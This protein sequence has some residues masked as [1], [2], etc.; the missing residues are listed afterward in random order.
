M[1]EAA[2]D[3]HTELSEAFDA[4][5]ASDGEPGT[6]VDTGGGGDAPAVSE[7]GGAESKPAKE[8]A[9]ATDKSA[10]GERVRDEHGRFVKQDGKPETEKQEKTEQEAEKPQAE[11]TGELKAAEPKEQQ[12]PPDAPPSTWRPTAKAEWVK[13]PSHVREEIKKR[14]ADFQKGVEQYKGAAQFGH[15]VYQAIQPYADNLRQTGIPPQDVIRNLLDLDN[16]LRSG[17]PDDKLGTI[18]WVAQQYGVNLPQVMGASGEVTDDMNA[19]VQRAM[20]PFMQQFQSFQQA[21][22][23]AEETQKKQQQEQARAEV[24]AFRDATDQS[25]KLKHPYFTNVWPNM[26]RMRQAGIAQSW[27]DAYTKACRADDEVSRAMDAEQ[28][29]QAEAK[30]LEDQ[31]KQ[32]EDAQR[33]KRANVVGQGGVGMS[34]TKSKSIRDELASNWDGQRI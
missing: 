1:A 24:L 12:A 33:A 17:T 27:E 3:L 14:E 8:D 15:N 11:Q 9:K 28:R 26:L 31:R 4:A 2:K 20:Q 29:N 25:G 18:L 7:A 6:T 34:D 22:K 23:T 10:G 32:A 5:E 16:K 30:R 13:L 21:Q 19:A